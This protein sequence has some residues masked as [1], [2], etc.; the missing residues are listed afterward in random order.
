[1]RPHPRRLAAF[2]VA[3]ILLLL[4]AT[5]V[6]AHE[7]RQVA[8]YDMEVGLIDEPVAVGDKSGLEFF[9]HKDDQP[10]EG[11]ESTVKA[12][13]TFGSQTM[14]LPITADDDDAGRYFSVFYPTAAG[15]YTFHL[16]GSIEGNAIDESFTSSPTG[17]DEVHAAQSGQFPV[18]FPPPDELASQAKQG[19]DAAAQLPIAFGL[20]IAGLVAGLLGLG[21][22]LAS[23]RRPSGPASPA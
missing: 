18:Q 3:G 19:A 17:F 15:P 16:T 8:G 9:V 22:A 10:V 21:V 20:G 12:T 2:G 11:L 14:D 6:L 5:P 23:R 7:E 4:A 13:V 1:M